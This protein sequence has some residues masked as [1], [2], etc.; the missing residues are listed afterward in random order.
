LVCWRLPQRANHIRSPASLF[1]H[2]FQ[3]VLPGF[4]VARADNMATAVLIRLEEQD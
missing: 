4:T 1:I 3:P 2:G